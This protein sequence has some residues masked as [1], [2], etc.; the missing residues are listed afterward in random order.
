MEKEDKEAKKQKEDK[1]E[2][3]AVVRVQ[4]QKEIEKEDKE[5]KKQ[6]VGK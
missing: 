4:R 2:I 3:E 6:K 5:V 1:G